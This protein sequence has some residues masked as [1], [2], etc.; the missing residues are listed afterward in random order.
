MNN[1]LFFYLT[2]T[3]PHCNSTRFD[4]ILYVRWRRERERQQQVGSLSHT[5]ILL[6]CYCFHC[7]R[8][9]AASAAAAATALLLLY[10]HSHS[11]D[12]LV[13]EREGATLHKN[14]AQES[15]AQRE[16]GRERESDWWSCV[17]QQSK[18]T[19]LERARY[20]ARERE[21]AEFASNALQ[22]TQPSP[23]F[24]MHWAGLRVAT[25]TA[26]TKHFGLF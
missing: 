17:L 21:S 22:M 25:M 1:T 11:C 8:S 24:T 14:K 9:V 18:V 23:H 16:R 26:V 19:P 3:F 4:S 6:F 5:L 7:R 2:K 12:V 10:F 20:T 15:G 13:G